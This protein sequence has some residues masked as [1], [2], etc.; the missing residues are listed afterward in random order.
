MHLYPHQRAVAVPALAGLPLWLR[1]WPHAGQALPRTWKSPRPLHPGSGPRDRGTML[2]GEGRGSA[3]GLGLRAVLLVPRLTA[4][5]PAPPLWASHQSPAARAIGWMLRTP[6]EPCCPAPTQP[7][8]DACRGVVRGPV[9]TCGLTRWLLA[10]TLWCSR[11][12]SPG[13]PLPPPLPNSP[14]R[15][16]ETWSLKT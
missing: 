12:E 3:G 8:P 5:I 7:L 16:Q 13:T 4:A 2:P 9:D 6:W 15:R 11:P 1:K 14:C 10:S